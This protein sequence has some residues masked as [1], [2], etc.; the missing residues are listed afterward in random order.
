MFS[1]NKHV[2]VEK[3]N[4]AENLLLKEKGEKLKRNNKLGFEEMTGNYDTH[5][6]SFIVLHCL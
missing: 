3:N 6:I 4:E 2:I 5:V 1:S